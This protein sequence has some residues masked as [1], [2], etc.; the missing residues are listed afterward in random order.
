MRTPQFW[1]FMRQADF[2]KMPQPLKDAFL[3]VNPDASKLRVMQEKDAERMR[4]FED[5][6][7]EQ[8]RSIRAPTLILLGDRDIVKPEHAVEL[9]RLIPGARLVILPGTHGEYLGELVMTPAPSRLP[10]VT[11][12]IVEYFLDDGAATGVVPVLPK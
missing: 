2:T 3:K 5:V 9:T 10:E 11:D 12:G 1:E 4:H 8:V 7:D 6:P